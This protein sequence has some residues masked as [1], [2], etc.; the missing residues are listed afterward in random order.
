MIEDVEQWDELEE[1]TELCG[2][3]T[4]F[5]HA[6]ALSQVL[7]TGCCGK[8]SADELSPVSSMHQ[9]KLATTAMT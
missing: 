3:H 5:K 9:L 6:F 1:L 7:S 2:S 4:V 8:D